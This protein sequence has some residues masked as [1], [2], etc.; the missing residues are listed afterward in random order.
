MLM[1][2]KPYLLHLPSGQAVPIVANLPHSGMIVPDAIAA[3]F[4]PEHLRSLP[5]TDWHLDQLYRSLPTLGITVLQAT[6]SRYVVDLNRPLQ[7]P[8]FGNFW[9]AVMPEKTAFDK[10][11]YATL[12]SP[13]QLQERIDTFYL[14][15]HQ[16][17]TALLQERIATFGHVYLLDLHSFGA[18]LTEAV[19]LGN[20]NGKTCSDSLIATV[21]KH[22]LSKGYQTV[23]NKVFNGGY[24][25]GHYGQMAGVEAL[26]I[27]LRYQVYLNDDVER[28]QPPAWDVPKFHAAQETINEIF[29]AIVQDL[30]VTETSLQ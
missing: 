9:A 10:P 1:N 12:P 21:E 5:H 6:H 3:Q 23:R 19:C 17:L 27:E 7:E 22:F 29:A 11:I 2:M 25:T 26:Q 24:I 14:P 20:R 30:S 13:E 18:L 8:L 16:K 15:Y 28:S 4:L